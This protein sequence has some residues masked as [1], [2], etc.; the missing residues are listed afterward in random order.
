MDPGL[1]LSQDGALQAFGLLALLLYFA[2]VSTAFGIGQRT[3]AYWLTAWG[4]LL[5]AGALLLS[6]EAS[7]SAG[8]LYALACVSDAMVAPLLL[9]GANAIHD[10]RPAWAWPLLVG[11]TAGLVRFGLARAGALGAEALLSGAVA[12]A[13]LLAAALQTFRA[14]PR[15]EL[16]RT[17]ASLMVAFAAIEVWDAIVDLLSGMNIVPLRSVVAVCLPL[18][19]FQILSCVLGLG[20]DLARARAARGLIEEERD[21]AHWRLETIFDQVQELIAEIGEDTRILYVNDRVRDLL[22][23]E[24]EDLLGRQ[25]IELV[26]EER[27]AAEAERFQKGVKNG[28]APGARLLDVCARD[29]TLVSLEYSVSRYDFM[30]ATRLLVV[31]RDVSARVANERALAEHKRRLEERI[32]E[33]TEALRASHERLRAQEQLAAVGTL[34]SGIAHEINNPVGAISAAAE[35]AL[36]VGDG[37]DAAAERERALRRI[38]EESARAGRIVRNVLRFAR[39][40]ET[41]KWAEDLGSVVQRSVE[42]VRSYALE[43]GGRIDRSGTPEPLPVIMSPIEIE[44]LI[45]NLL[46]NAVESREGGVRIRVEVE[47]VG[48]RARL[49]IHDDG[50]GMTEE[51]RAHAFDPFYTTRLR[52]GGSGLG[53]AIVH[54][55]VQDHGGTIELPIVGEPGAPEACAADPG[56]PPDVA[57]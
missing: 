6:T 43:R 24:P 21:A 26:P 52:E 9:M 46:H 50:R 18:A 29:G 40:G 56:C 42:A 27:R 39:H 30:G 13:F 48:D 28:F 2:A 55:I 15:F 45:V 1:A 14:P 41:L 37:E 5:L 11:L 49:S 38:V 31:V 57:G 35:F 51:E 17:I 44:Q 47:R 16:R 23:F 3:L 33:R 20:A 32:E 36:L 54:R 34:A 10:R 19:A 4:T 25:A 12:P 22:G 8:A 53:L 7:P